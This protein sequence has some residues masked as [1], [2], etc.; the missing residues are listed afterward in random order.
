MKSN[1][2]VK[3]DSR[4]NLI[5]PVLDGRGDKGAD[6]TTGSRNRSPSSKGQS[7]LSTSKMNLKVNNLVEESKTDKKHYDS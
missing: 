4:L 3:D 6:H 2:K 7:R 5:K 1:E